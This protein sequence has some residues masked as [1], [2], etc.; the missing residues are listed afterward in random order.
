MERN[1]NFHSAA[2][3][4]T[5]EHPPRS[6]ECAAAA[7]VL[8]SS[9]RNFPFARRPSVA[10]P[11][12]AP[13]PSLPS[14]FPAFHENGT[15]PAKESARRTISSSIDRRG[16]RFFRLSRRVPRDFPAVSFPADCPPPRNPFFHP[17]FVENSPCSPPRRLLFSLSRARQVVHFPGMTDRRIRFL[18]ESKLRPGRAADTISFFRVTS[19]NERPLDSDSSS[20]TSSQEHRSNRRVTVY[21]YSGMKLSRLESRHLLLEEALKSQLY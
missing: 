4:K 17:L 15:R 20:S 2:F 1:R 8:G 12:P 13:A 5:N 10:A 18:V 21:F 3:I 11:D 16:A 19:V 9:D 14:R 6:F 7:D